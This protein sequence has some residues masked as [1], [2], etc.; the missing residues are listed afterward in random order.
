M[1]NE[2]RHV[3][4]TFAALFS[5]VKPFSAN[6]LKKEDHVL[7]DKYDHNQFVV[8]GEVNLQEV[9]DAFAYQLNKG[10]DFIK[11]DSRKRLNEAMVHEFDL[12]E[13]I[14]DTMVLEEGCGWEENVDIYIK[15]LQFDDF[16]TDLIDLEVRHYG[17]AY[18]ESFCKRNVEQLIDTVHKD[19]RLHY[20]G[21]FSGNELVGSVFAF[22][23]GDYVMIDSLLVDE[24]HRH[25]LI[26][27]T[28]LKFIVQVFEGKTIFLHADEDDTPK[29]MYMNLGFVNK[30]VL[31]EYTKV[32][33]KNS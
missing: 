1:I 2:L 12:E 5:E 25:Q 11:F 31:Y 33:I 15:D 28:L 8:N 3:E 18:G 20:Y 27:T 13:S 24:K 4:D 32:G 14:T 9:K 17:E 23:E 26:A 30:D 29:E 6:L 22:C 16:G 10:D 21:A 19:A 7:Y